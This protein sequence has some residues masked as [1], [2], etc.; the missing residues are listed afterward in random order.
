MAR[1]KALKWRDEEAVVAGDTRN[2]DVKKLE[3]QEGRFLRTKL[4]VTHMSYRPVHQ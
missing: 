2:S 1:L 4:E 3:Y